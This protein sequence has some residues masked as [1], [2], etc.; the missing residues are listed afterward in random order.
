MA[1]GAAGRQ[2]VATS[3]GLPVQ[4]PLVL[5]DFSGMAA[6][7]VRAWSASGWISCV[8]WQSL[9]PRCPARVRRLEALP[10]RPAV[11]LLDLTVVTVAAVDA[12]D[13]V[14][15]HVVEADEVSVAV[16][17]GEVAVDRGREGLRVDVDRDLERRHARRSC[18]GLRDIRGSPRCRALSAARGTEPVG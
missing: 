18:R 5:A 1:V 6:G 7:A 3:R 2:L 9:Q 10:W 11:D 4:A 13:V 16:I 8:P 15:V 14:I 12:F 17:A